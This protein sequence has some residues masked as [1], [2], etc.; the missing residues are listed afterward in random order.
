MAFRRLWTW[1]GDDSNLKRISFLWGVTLVLF[2]GL[3]G[4]GYWAYQTYYESPNSNEV[5]VAPN[6]DTADSTEV[7]LR[8]SLLLY[9]YGVLRRERADLE[10]AIRAFDAAIA[11]LDSSD[12]QHKLQYQTVLIAQMHVY[13]EMGEDEMLEVSSQVYQE[14]FLEE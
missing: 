11:L 7:Q 1:L 13:S 4:I 14:L 3:S 8:T 10:G 9:E 2:G 6:G 12:P 5:I